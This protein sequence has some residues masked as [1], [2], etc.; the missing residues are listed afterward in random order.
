MVCDKRVTHLN[1]SDVGVLGNILVLV[2]SILGQLSLLLLNRKLNQEE[3]NRLERHD[4]D[5][6]RALAGDVLVEEGEGGGCLV[7]ADELVS[8]LQDV[9]RLLVR[10]RRL[11]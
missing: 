6:S 9:L 11:Y 3:H 2:Q 7:D 10:R 8:P 4:G 1:G 5:I